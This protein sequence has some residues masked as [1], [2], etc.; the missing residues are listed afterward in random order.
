M[1]SGGVGQGQSIASRFFWGLFWLPT[2]Q[3]LGDHGNFLIGR[4]VF[5][6]SINY[7][8]QDTISPELVELFKDN[9]CQG[10]FFESGLGHG[11]GIREGI[12]KKS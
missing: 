7:Q 9:L 10:A 3:L 2:G 6:S 11:Q 4:Q 1:I 8:K 5:I 12:V